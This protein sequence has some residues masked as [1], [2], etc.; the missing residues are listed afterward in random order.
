MRG[1]IAD[2][3]AIDV[4]LAA[5]AQRFQE[6]R[7]GEG[8]LLAGDDRLGM[9]GHIF[10]RSYCLSRAA[11]RATLAIRQHTDNYCSVY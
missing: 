6:F 8:P 10:L 2:A 11:L 5:V 4:N 1:D 3:L 9:I 7:S